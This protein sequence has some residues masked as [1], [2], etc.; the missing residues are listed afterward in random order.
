MSETIMSKNVNTFFKSCIEDN[1]IDHESRKTMK[2]WVRQ[3][4]MYRF[5]ITALIYKYVQFNELYLDKGNG[6][7]NKMHMRFDNKLEQ[8]FSI[9]ENDPQLTFHNMQVYISRLFKSV[10]LYETIPLKFFQFINKTSM[11]FNDNVVNEINNTDIHDKMR[12]TR[13]KVFSWISDYIN[14]NNLYSMNDDGTYN[15]N[16]YVG[17]KEF[18]TLFSI[19][20]HD[21][22]ITKLSLRR[23]INT[24][25]GES[26]FRY[27]EVDSC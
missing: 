7:I 14:H 22:K 5:E 21:T 17:D 4:I 25:Y 26:L 11:K 6:K 9:V 12:I 27:R 2:K 8:L 1:K 24:L 20:S 10:T 19:G 16:I 13:A 15:T 18:N 23:Y 3:N